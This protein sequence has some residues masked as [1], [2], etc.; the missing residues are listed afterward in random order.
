MRQEEKQ[1]KKEPLPADYRRRAVVYTYFLESYANI[2][3]SK[4]LRQVGKESGQT[5][6]T[7][8]FNNMLR[9]RCPGTVRK[10]L[11][12]SKNEAMHEKRMRIFID[13]YNKSL[14]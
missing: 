12:F 8:R 2:I 5:A 4:R 10:T 14:L 3:P 9:Q 13:C 1:K 6:H 7:E 11:F